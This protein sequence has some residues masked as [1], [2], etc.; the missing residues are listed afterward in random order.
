[1]EKTGHWFIERQT[2]DEIAPNGNK[3]TVWE[4][5]QMG[6]SRAMPLF[7]KTY[8]ELM[9]SGHATTHMSWIDG[10]KIHVV[11]VFDEVTQQVAGGIAFEYRVVAREGW[12]ILS[13]TDP[14]YRGQ[15]INQTVNGYFENIIRAR[16]GYKIASHV[17]VG[18]TSRLKSAERAGLAPE[19]YRMAKRIA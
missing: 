14:S 1:M 4:S 9:D 13:F 8:A 17:H 2:G 15:R 7:M 10:N 11:Y 18:N 5:E 3:L 16:G 12:I 19:F 6:G